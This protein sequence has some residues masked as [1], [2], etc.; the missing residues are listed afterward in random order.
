MTL[1]TMPP[2]DGDPWLWKDPQG[3][4]R[5]V[6]PG[7]PACIYDL[8]VPGDI[9]QPCGKPGHRYPCGYRCPEHAPAQAGDSDDWDGFTCPREFC[10]LGLRVTEND[11]LP[12]RFGHPK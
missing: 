5:A 8:A 12:I 2:A 10:D 4:G 11:S 1:P 6:V 3:R 9:Y 7:H